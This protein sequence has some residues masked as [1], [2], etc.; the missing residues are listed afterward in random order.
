MRG[1]WAAATSW[2]ATEG[3]GSSS[4]E[5]PSHARRPKQHR[6]PRSRLELVP[7]RAIRRP[8]LT[9]LD[10][11]VKAA[12]EGSDA[13]KEQAAADLC[14]MAHDQWT[15][16]DDRDCI[17]EAGGVGPLVALAEDGTVVQKEHAATALCVLTFC[18]DSCRDN[19]AS[20]GGIDALVTLAAEGTDV[21]REEAAVA[22]CNLAH[23]P[24]HKANIAKAGGIAPLVKLVCE[25]T[26]TQKEH[27]AAALYGAHTA[28]PQDNPGLIVATCPELHCPVCPHPQHRRCPHAQAQPRVLLHVE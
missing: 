1:M 2:F 12:V 28:P 11:A 22:L 24:E 19:V 8:S 4:L 5:E 7:P 27:G 13:E 9:A 15:D 6:S 26:A 21:Q 23:K 20:A 10:L 3:A 17:A 25:G 18:N 16:P 14:L